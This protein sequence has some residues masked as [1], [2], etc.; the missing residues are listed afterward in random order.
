MQ[1]NHLFCYEL[2]PLIYETNENIFTNLY[3]IK[4][5]NTILFFKV[6]TP[7]LCRFT[8]K[9]IRYDIDKVSIYR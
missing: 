7:N 9:P 2:L 1:S 4:I 8:L 6:I 5:R 3:S